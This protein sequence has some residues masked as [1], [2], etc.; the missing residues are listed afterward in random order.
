MTRPRELAVVHDPSGSP[1]IAAPSDDTT[2]V[3]KRD[4]TE[5]YIC[6]GCWALIL[7]GVETEDVRG[8]LFLC[9]DCG[10]VNQ[11]PST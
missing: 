10:T 3:L 2:I 7:E 4:G 1:V 9:N 6:A 5:N 11:V 8:L